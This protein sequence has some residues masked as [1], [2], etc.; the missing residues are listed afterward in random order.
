MLLTIN[1]ARI[2]SVVPFKLPFIPTHLESKTLHL[3]I[4]EFF[5]LFQVGTMLHL[6]DIL[7]KVNLGSNPRPRRIR[8]ANNGAAFDLV[9]AAKPTVHSYHISSDLIC[10]P[11]RMLVIT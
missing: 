10:V 7:V 8:R 4:K 3:T 11:I 9:E 1:G 5:F 6:R 2:L